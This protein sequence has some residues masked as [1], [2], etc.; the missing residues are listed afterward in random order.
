M[1]ALGKNDSWD[2]VTLP[3]EKKS[4]GYKWVFVVKQKANGTVE[5]YKARLVARG[6]TQTH[7]IDYQETFAPVAKMNTVRLA[8]TLTIGISSKNVGS[9]VSKFG[10]FDIDAP[11]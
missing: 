6:F 4:V 1:S 11:T 5:R 9:L 7:G 3:L 10:M 2:L 8:D